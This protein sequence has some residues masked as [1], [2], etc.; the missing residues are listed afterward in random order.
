M[1][2]QLVLFQP[3]A[4][5]LTNISIGTEYYISRDLAVRAGFYTDYANTPKIASGGTDQSEHIDLYGVTAS[6]SHYTRNTPVTLGG[7]KTYGKGQAQI[8][9]GVTPVQTAVVDGWMLFLSSAY[10]Y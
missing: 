10:S 7:G 6:V 9:G 8:V 2:G 4:N 3:H 1:E 5:S